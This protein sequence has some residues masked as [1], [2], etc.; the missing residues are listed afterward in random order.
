MKLWHG[1]PCLY[2]L[3]C[4]E[5]QFRRCGDTVCAIEATCIQEVRC[6]S[7]SAVAACSA[8][9]DGD[10]C[11]TSLFNGVCAHG[12]C[13]VDDADG[14]FVRDGEDNCRLL[15]NASQQDLDGDGFGDACDNCP[16]LATDNDHDED[17]DRVG[18]ACDVCP[19]LED[20]QRDFDGN[21]VGDGCEFGTRRLFDPFVEIDYEWITDGPVW[22]WRGDSVAPSTGALALRRPTLELASPKL[23]ML[24]NLRATRPWSDGDKVVLRLRNADGGADASCE[25]ACNNSGCAVRGYLEQ[26]GTL[27]ATE[28]QASPTLRFAL[29]LEIG[30]TKSLYCTVSQET[31]TTLATGFT[32]LT[33]P[34]TGSPE[35][36]SQ[37]GIEIEAFEAYD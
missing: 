35:L 1:V 11:S 16:V 3:A 29:G 10:A 9:A 17:G 13:W 12:A 26:L 21:G 14:D 2:L 31:G 15:A 37:P 5:P 6:A 27:S 36:E 34:V 4:I 32:V 24:L 22:N 33:A 19:A 23:G 7:S 25:I 30:S 28:F 8:S 20:F 18:D